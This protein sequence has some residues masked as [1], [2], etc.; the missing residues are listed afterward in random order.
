MNATR[1]IDKA[2]KDYPEYIEKCKAMSGKYIA[3][4]Q[5]EEDRYPMW[6]GLDHPAGPGIQ[7]I[8]RL[9]REEL[10][11]LQKEYAHI[12]KEMSE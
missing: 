12:F 11:A 10:K 2:H 3:L 4:E 9:Y 6:E 1:K 5:A 8:K 7:T